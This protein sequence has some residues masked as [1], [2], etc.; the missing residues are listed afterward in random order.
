M[1]LLKLLFS[2]QG[3]SLVRLLCHSAGALRMFV[4]WLEKGSVQFNDANFPMNALHV[5]VGLVWAMCA[6]CA[7]A[8]VVVGD[9]HWV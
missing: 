2:R 8:L 3:S 5:C 1:V 6:V 7:W 4:L 9:V